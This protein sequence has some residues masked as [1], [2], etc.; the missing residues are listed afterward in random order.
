MTD[1]WPDLAGRID[2]KVHT[3]PVRV[4]YEDTDFSGVVYHANYLRYCERGRSDFLRLLGVVHSELYDG[5]KDAERLGFAVRD[6]EIDFIKP[7]RID[8]VLEVRTRFR[9]L[10]RARFHLGQ[11]IYRGADKLF[12]ATLTAV[13]IDGSGRPRRLPGDMIAAFSE[14]LPA[15]A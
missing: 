11:D 3:L 14:F 10:G 8:D 6:M 1:V 4:Y 15:P 9:S 12:G 7:A 13:V 5:E 2:G